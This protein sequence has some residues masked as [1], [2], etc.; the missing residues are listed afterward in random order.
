[1]ASD[2]LAPR[3]VDAVKWGASLA[4]IG[5]YAA[6]GL[7]WTTWAVP[8]FLIGVLGWLAVGIAWRDRAIMLIHLVAMMAMVAGLITRG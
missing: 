7:G 6:T 4:Q 5:G 3:G 2:I 8:L 1:M